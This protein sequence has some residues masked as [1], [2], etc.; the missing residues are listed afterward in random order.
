[1]W[2]KGK[3]KRHMTLKGRFGFRTTSDAS[4]SISLPRRLVPVACKFVYNPPVRMHLTFVTLSHVI[5]TVSPFF[6]DGSLQ[7][8]SSNRSPNFFW[9]ILTHFEGICLRREDLMQWSINEI[10][11]FGDQV[12]WSFLVVWQLF[13]RMGFISSEE[14]ITRKGKWQQW[15]Y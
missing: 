9:R 7:A 15:N 3:V 2:G 5:L 6:S 14:E 11:L 8:V 12:G 10:F 4:R 13:A 1:M